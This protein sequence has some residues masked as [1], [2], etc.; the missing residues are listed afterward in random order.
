MVTARVYYIWVE[1]TRDT[2][3]DRDSPA[4]V[5]APGW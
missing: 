3:V 5:F 1:L 4:K 2:S